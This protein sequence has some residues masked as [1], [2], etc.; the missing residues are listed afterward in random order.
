DREAGE[1][2]FRII[3]HHMDDVFWTGTTGDSARDYA[4]PAYARTWGRDPA[5]LESDP[6]SWLEAVHPEDRE[7]VEDVV[8]RRA[9][10]GYEIQYRLLRPGGETRW[11][12]ERA[13]AVNDAST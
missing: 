5:E 10:L 2:R 1:A 11:I 8:R 9:G 6:R 4:S 7:R 12:A 3:A 13:I